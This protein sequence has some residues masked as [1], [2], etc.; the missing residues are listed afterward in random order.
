MN[1][2]KCSQ[3]RF[4]FLSLQDPKFLYFNCFLARLWLLT[5]LN[6]VRSVANMNLY[7]SLTILTLT[8]LVQRTQSNPFT[9]SGYIR[10]QGPYFVDAKCEEFIFSGWNS[11]A[12]MEAGAGDVYALPRDPSF[13]DGEDFLSWLFDTAAGAGMSVGRAFGHGSSPSFALQPSPGVYNEA[14]FVGLD[15]VIYE[16]GQRNIRL[17]LTMAGN[18]KSADSK[19]NYVQ[20]SNTAIS[21]DDFY[22]DAT[23][24][25]LFKNHLNVMAN[26]V[27]TFSGIQY[28]DDPTIF[29]WNLMNE[30]RCAC[31][32]FNQGYGCSPECADALN[33]WVGEMSNYLKSVDPNHMITVGEEGFYSWNALNRVQYN[34]GNFQDRAARA[35]ETGV[36]EESLLWAKRSGQNF[37]WDHR[38][39]AIDYAGYH[40]WL[41][42]WDLVGRFDFFKLWIDI[43]TTDAKILQK[44]VVLEEFG[45]I[46]NVDTDTARKNTRDP[47]F[48]AAYQETINSFNQDRELKGVMWWEWDTNNGQ[49]P[50]Q[51]GVRYTDVTFEELVAPQS[52]AVNNFQEARPLV[53][54]CIP[55]GAFSYEALYLTPASSQA[56]PTFVYYATQGHGLLATKEGDDVELKNG[57]AFLATLSPYECALECEA[58]IQCTAFSFNA[59]Q[60]RCYLKSGSSYEVTWSEGGWQSYYRQEGETDCDSP[61]CVGCLGSGTCIRCQQGYLLDIPAGDDSAE[62]VPCSD[63]PKP[64]QLNRVEC[65]ATSD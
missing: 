10:A 32:V 12:L 3:L 33:N 48:E 5:I 27:N 42:N 60:E 47:V 11:W 40:L 57:D 59:R 34:P 62:C 19:I 41:D 9:A 18:W 7:E 30:P 35:A 39:Q 13:L 14:A 31:D 28:K 64:L 37:T 46:V 21:A 52:Q 43:H 6:V 51:Y 54:N 45:K 4:N 23:T 44:P 29:A 16:A 25:Q 56:N 26:R 65:S 1:R 22:S 8:L 38:F 61:N 36:S 2:L 50:V 58:Q 24:R 63:F 53:S 20:W 49:K 15:K 55:A 17:V